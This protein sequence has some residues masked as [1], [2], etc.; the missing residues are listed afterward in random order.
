MLCEHY[1]EALIEAAASDAP[2]PGDL[3]AHLDGCDNCR[4]AFEQEQTLFAAM[5]GGLRLTANAEVPV[6]LLPRV[7]AQLS[8]Q[9][10]ARRSWVPAW[11]VL[12]TTAAI[13]LAAFAVRGW[14][15]DTS[16]QNAQKSTLAHAVLP[17]ETSTQPLGASPQTEPGPRMKK[18]GT[19]SRA[20]ASPS[21]ERVP[22]LLP[23]GQRVV[24]DSWLD[25]LRTGKLKVG[26]LLTQKSDLPLQDLRVSPLGVSPIELKPLADVRG[27]PTSQDAEAKR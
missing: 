11:A 20:Q 19:Q 26:N 14:R 5:D 23:A 25:D 16:G 2:P 8:G 1:K 6:S 7:H 9:S 21:V 15:H 27:E 13:V 3:R 17:V 4:V 24:I 18:R 12:A 10:V 22:V